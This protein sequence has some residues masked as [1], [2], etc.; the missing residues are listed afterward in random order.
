MYSYLTGLPQSGQ[1]V[2]VQVRL[3]RA[4]A[5]LCGLALVGDVQARITRVGAVDLAGLQ[6]AR[7]S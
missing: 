5:L 4:E 6:D 3:G 7:C 1:L 2:L